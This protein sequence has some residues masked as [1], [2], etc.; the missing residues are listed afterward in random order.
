METTLP[1]AQK[2]GRTLS[3]AII[4]PLVDAFHTIFDTP[5]G[6]NVPKANVT[7]KDSEIQIELAVPGLSKEDFVIKA[8]GN[9]LTISAE[10]ET[11]RSEGD[12]K[13]SYRREYNYSS[14]SRSFV[15]PDEAR[16][17][18]ARATYKDGILHITIAKEETSKKD[19]MAIPVE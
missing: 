6:V 8:D 12:E 15:L 13:A 3:T 18:Q 16:I 5:L 7:E 19:S 4:D 9:M 11:D 1:T 10:K 14:F 2:V 17:D